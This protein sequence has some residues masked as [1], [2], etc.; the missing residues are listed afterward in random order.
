MPSSPPPPTPRGASSPSPPH[1]HHLAE[2]LPSASF[3]APS[4]HTT[5]TIEPSEA[6]EKGELSVGGRTSE[7]AAHSPR[8]A[9][10]A[11]P[12]LD[13]Y[14]D[15]GL[16]A[17]SVVGGAWCISFTSWG[18]TNA[19][20]VFQTYYQAN[21]LSEYSHSDISWIGSLQLALVLA[22][23]I[24][25]GKA[26]DAGYVTWLLAG[27]AC[28]WTAGL[29]GFSEATQYYQ[30]FL[31]Q[32]VACGLGAGMAFIPAAS[33]VSHWFKKRRAT[34]LGILA[35]GSSFGGIV[36]PVLLNQLFPRIGF[37]W[38]VRVAAFLTLA[39]LV[40]AILTVRSRL[41]P[42]KVE[43]IFDFS[44]LREKAFL[45]VTIGETIIMLCVA[46]L[47][48]PFSRLYALKYGVSSNL[49]LYSLSI[50]NAASIF[51]RIIPNWLAD[52]YGP[53]TVLVPHCFMSGVLIFLFLPMCKSAGGLVAFTI[54]F[55][56]ASGAY[57]SMMP[58]LVASLTKDM[59]EVGHRTATMFLIISVAALVGTPITGAII[60]R[61][62]GSYVAAMCVAGS[63]TLVGSCFNAAAWWVVSREKGR[64]WV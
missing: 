30:I 60:S 26:F 58:A 62:D 54:L 55:G 12:V 7:E 22:C 11:A 35:T 59:R 4:E 56:F 1:P 2:Q 9:E 27:A 15:G 34:A 10:K 5:A 31:G 23:A 41:P 61:S 6:T 32:G 17:W 42:R 24:L 40:T 33:S 37:G 29:F 45:L 43:K 64:F 13:D 14:P 52:T 28:C 44:P 47:P 57:V 19:Y 46:L 8:D 50:L 48:C 20:G 63:L 49:A 53:L 38:T 36:Y 21:Q 16:R 18:F 39:M 51:G 3:Q 25:V